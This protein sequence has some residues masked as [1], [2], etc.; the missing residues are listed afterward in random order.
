MADASSG[1]IKL[2]CNSAC[3]R[4]SRIQSTCD[5]CPKAGCRSGGHSTFR[6]SVQVRNLPS[7][8]A[9]CASSPGMK[10]DICRGSVNPAGIPLESIRRR[11]NGPTI[12]R[13]NSGACTCGPLKQAAMELA[14][15]SRIC[16]E[17]QLPSVFPG[18]AVT[19]S[20]STTTASRSSKC[21]FRRP[22]TD[23]VLTGAGD[24]ESDVALMPQYP[25]SP[26]DADRLASRTRNTIRTV[27]ARWSEIARH[28]AT[29]RIPGNERFLPGT[30]AA[31]YE[32]RP[33]HQC[34]N[35]DG[36]GDPLCRGL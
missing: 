35:G 17:L 27:T 5:N 34:F 1:T 26:W 14:R 3:R 30:Q 25:L 10:C 6:R 29:N 4:C 16:A 7:D 18:L 31:F 33:V 22:A 20:A 2:K 24:M 21:S 19:D 28:F 12:Q 11:T 32:I 13:T 15:W 8:V 23:P 36:R 9:T